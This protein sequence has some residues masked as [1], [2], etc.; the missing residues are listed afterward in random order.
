MLT[1]SVC[2]REGVRSLSVVFDISSEGFIH[3]VDQA[4]IDVVVIV[5]NYLDVLSSVDN[6]LVVR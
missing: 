5:V 2:S 1:L 3:K 6:K 4:W